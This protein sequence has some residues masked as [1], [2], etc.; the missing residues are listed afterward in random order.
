MKLKFKASFAALGAMAVILTGCST[1][2]PASTT[3]T[4]D[5]GITIGVS[6]EHLNEIRSA[7]LAGIKDAAKKNGD[8]VVFV[9]ADDDAQKQA[10]QIQ[11]LIQTQKVDA[12]IVI[13]FNK[14][15]ITSSIALAKANNVPFLTIDRATTDQENISFQITGDPVADGKLVAEQMIAADKDLKVLQLIG[16]LTDQNAVGRRDGFV[17]GLKGQTAV[18]IVADVPTD[19]DPTK[20]LDGTSNALEKNPDINAIYVPSDYLLPSVLSALDAAG[21]L[22]PVGDPDHVFIVTIDG[23]PV[24]CQALADKTI[25]A[26]IATLVG[27]FGTQAVEAARAL[28]AGE[29]VDPHIVEIAGLAINQGNF[30]DEKANVWGCADVK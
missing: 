20:A 28:S 17:A 16:G 12:L 5:G 4:S 7:E 30:S 18:S 11:D 14:D 19:W 9:S 10:S 29:T 21:K 3:D 23:D 22:K 8:K 1:A 27:D 6:F 26:D 15:Q 2:T 24:G 25:D 13:A